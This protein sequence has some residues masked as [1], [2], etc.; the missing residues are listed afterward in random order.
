VEAPASSQTL[1]GWLWLP[2]LLLAVAVGLGWWFLQGKS[3]P[4]AMKPLTDMVQR[5]KGKWGQQGKP[6]AMVPGPAAGAS[7]P[8]P[9]VVTPPPLP[10][11]APDL[12]EVPV[13]WAQAHYQGLVNNK[14][15]QLL[16]I[17]GEVI[18]KGKDPRGPIR[19][20]ATLTDYRHQPL[21]EEVVYAGTTL[22]DTEL[23]TLNPDEI[24][25]WLLRPGGRSQERVLN[26]GKKQ[27]FT[28]VFFGVSDNLAE[29]QS[30][31]QL[32]VVEGPVVPGKA[33]HQ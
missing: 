31:F 7:T 9:T 29:T 26:P 16:I 11:P 4:T 32:V 6:G 23:K 25:G 33:A 30:G 8:A 17:Q 5:L 1:R 15:G 28:V 19:L 13:D 12:S 27:P 18:N 10:V 22:T 21:R 3:A 24:K 20:R 14:A 2:A